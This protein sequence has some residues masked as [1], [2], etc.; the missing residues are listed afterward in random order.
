M[1]SSTSAW[2]F[3]KS[4]KH[5]LEKTDKRFTPGPGMYSSSTKTFEKAPSWR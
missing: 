1:K 3:G 5:E 2:S 4:K